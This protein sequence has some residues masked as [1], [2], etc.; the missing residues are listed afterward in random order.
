MELNTTSKIRD[1]LKT[2]PR[3]E[4]PAL[5]AESGVPPSTIEKIAYG[6]TANPGFDNA[7][8]LAE[9]LERRARSKRVA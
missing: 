5:S 1:R 2:I 6:V 8:G 3:S 4:W 7:I 9:A